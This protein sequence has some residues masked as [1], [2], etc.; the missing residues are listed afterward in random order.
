MR[1]RRT[2]TTNNGEELNISDMTDTHL[3]NTFRMLYKKGCNRRDPDYANIVDECHKRGMKPFQML[4]QQDRQMH[5]K[6]KG[7]WNEEQTIFS[8]II[9]SN[10]FDGHS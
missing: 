9:E 7:W 3:F 8:Q 5:K 1:N 10:Y 6:N 4:E 2:W